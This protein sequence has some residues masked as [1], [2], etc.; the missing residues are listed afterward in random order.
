MVADDLKNYIITNNCIEQILLSL[1]CHS[2]K[3]FATEIRAGLPEHKSSTAVAVKKDNLKTKVYTHDKTI[4]GD[5]FT[6][7]M[8]L[9][10]CSFFKALKYV[11]E[12]LG[13][14]FTYIDTTH[15]EEEKIDILKVFKR[16]K[17][18]SVQDNIPLKRYNDSILNRF[19]NLPVIWFIKEGISPA[20]QIKFRIG[21]CPE[22]NRITIP[23]KY[24]NSDDDEYMGVIGRTVL[25]D[26]EMLDIPKYFP[27][28]AFPKSKNLY[29]YHENY[30][31]IQ[32]TGEVI[33]FEAEKSV[34]KADTMKINN[35]VALGGHEI[36]NEQLKILI[37]LNVDII[38][39]FDKDICEEFLITTGNRFKYC[40]NV[41]YIW[42]KYNLLDE[43]DSPIDKGYKRFNYLLK[44]KIQL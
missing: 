16:V 6:L 2:I 33:I 23:V 4:N 5:I 14:P 37:G 21:F 26:W 1:N 11:H 20:T 36:S 7:V 15:Q 38:I 27:L 22:H 32:E 24:W 25:P 40:R 9:K 44:H 18:S 34:L 19:I 8:E 30:K 10:E 13:I 41:Y 43:K 39:A 3:T 12:L 29:G 28:I 35:C 42:D 31:A 17:T